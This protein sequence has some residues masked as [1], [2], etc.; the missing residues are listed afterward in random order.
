MASIDSTSKLNIYASSLLSID[1]YASLTLLYTPIVGP[2]TISIYETMFSLIDRQKL[3]SSEI[4]YSDILKLLGIDDDTFNEGRLKLEALGLLETLKK[5]S[6]YIFLIKMP[7]T[8]KLF[9]QD[10]VFRIYLGEA[11]GEEI[12]GRIV[13]QFSIAQVDRLLYKNVTTSFDQVFKPT[14]GDDKFNVDGFIMGRKPN[15]SITIK[16]HSFDFD[17]FIAQVDDRL[18]SNIAEARKVIT[19]LSYVYGYDTDTLVSLFNQSLNSSGMFDVKIFNRK[20]NLLNKKINQG[21]IKLITKPDMSEEER[22]VMNS[23]C[24]ASVKDMLEEL[25]PSYDQ[26]SLKNVN[27]IFNDPNI[28][29]GRDVLNIMIFYVLK[30]K[31]GKLPTALY[32]EKVAD[33]WKANGYITRE[34]AWKFVRGIKEDNIENRSKKAYNKPVTK[35]TNEYTEKYI[36]NISEGFE[37]L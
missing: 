17:T 29:L 21:D 14:K 12:L 11:V 22:E 10:S 4:K 19:N 8:P 9:L 36:E 6:D 24:N 20:A 31:D 3:I 35:K 2:R 33:E 5:D 30:K 26:I 15:V 16:N 34:A 37:K 1:D 13:E 32:F 7:L 18:I 23:V 28:D 25:F 27:G